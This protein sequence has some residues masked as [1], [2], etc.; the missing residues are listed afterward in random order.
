[1]RGYYKKKV[2]NI[3]K[4]AK[5][6]W[7]QGNVEI[8]TD[9]QERKILWAIAVMKGFID[10]RD[11]KE[12]HHFYLDDPKKDVIVWEKESFLTQAVKAFLED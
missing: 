1:M 12:I 2:E 4:R 8:P 7:E 6:F 9:I 10:V 5:T 3:Y 11:E